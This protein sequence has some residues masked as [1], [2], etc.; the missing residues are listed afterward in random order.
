MAE[1]KKEVSDR[2]LKEQMTEDRRRR[3]MT[4][5]FGSKPRVEAEKPVGIFLFWSDD[6]AG[7]KAGRKEER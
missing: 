5:N 1:R 4:R 7:K 2:T 3:L 6:D